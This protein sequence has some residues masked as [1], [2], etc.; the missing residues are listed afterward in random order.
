[1]RLRELLRT[2]TFRLSVLYG[3]VFTLGAIA[4]LGLVYQ[5][6][7][8]YLTHRVDRILEVEAAALS[9]SP[10]AEL[11]GSLGCA[12]ARAFAP[13]PAPAPPR[14]PA[15]AIRRGGAA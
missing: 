8:G 1:M 6:S 3:L 14:A 13:A 7:A 12:L 2:T 10:P 4:L 9:V 11:S 15:R 5:Q